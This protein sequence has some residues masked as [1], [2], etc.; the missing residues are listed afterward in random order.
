[1]RIGKVRIDRSINEEY[2]TDGRSQLLESSILH[3][4]FN[5]GFH[6][7]LEKHNRYSTMEAELKFRS[8]SGKWS[9]SDFRHPDPAIRRKALKALV[10]A[11]PARPLIIFMGLYFVKG[12]IL[13]GQAGFTYCM[14]K[15]IY[16]YMIDCKVRELRRRAKG[17]PV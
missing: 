15:T 17:L 13:D 6:A 3:Y 8:G 1:M 16:E 11:L 14:L 5:K 2:R 4:P 9:W 12:G 10:Y 7:W